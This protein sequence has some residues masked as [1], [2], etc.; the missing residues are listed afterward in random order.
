MTWTVYA[1]G[2][3]AVVLAVLRIIPVMAGAINIAAFNEV[4][5]KL[6]KAGNIDRAG[7]LADAV[8]AA[9]YGAV[10]SSLVAR[11]KELNAADGRS[12]IA[13]SLR[14]TLHKVLA[15]QSRR[16]HRLDWLY[17]GSALAAGVAA[18]GPVDEVPAGASIGLPAVAVVLILWSWTRSRRELRN[19]KIGGDELVELLTTSVAGEAE[20]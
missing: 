16:I 11:A 13:D 6:L 20:A 4:M 1:G 14:E 5:A 18:L 17:V 3:V 2:I 19:S 8:S 15:E 12:L 9:L 7:K 10:V